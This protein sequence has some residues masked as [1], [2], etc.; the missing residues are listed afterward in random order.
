MR[1]AHATSTIKNGT[2][3]LFGATKRIVQMKYVPTA[4]MSGAATA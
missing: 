3:H 4:P 1:I 2:S